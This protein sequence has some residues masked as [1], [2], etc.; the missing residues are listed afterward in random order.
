MLKMDNIHK[1]ISYQHM[2]AMK[3]IRASYKVDLTGKHM[4]NNLVDSFASIILKS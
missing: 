4:T 2:L 3:Q 1:E